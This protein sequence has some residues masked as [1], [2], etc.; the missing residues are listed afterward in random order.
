[1]KRVQNN[2]DEVARRVANGHYV[3][4]TMPGVDSS[5]VSDY[6][7]RVKLLKRLASTEKEN[8]KARQ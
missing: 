8:T 1:M 3:E 4:Q 7:N 6:I 2:L 5:D